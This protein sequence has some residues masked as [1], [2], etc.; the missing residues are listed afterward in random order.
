MRNY[1][2]IGLAAV[3]LFVGLR[4]SAAQDSIINEFYGYGVHAYFSGE[5][6]QAHDFLT[7]VVEQGSRDPRV[8]YFRGL[9]YS[10]L[11][12]P[13]QA[14]MDFEKGA[15]LETGGADRV[16]PIGRSLQRVQGKLRLSVEKHRR[17]ARLV[18][19]KR[20]M[21]MRAERYEN[22]RN[23]EGEVLR[24]PTR[25]APTKAE[26]LVGPA[27]A[28]DQSDPFG[29]GVAAAEPEVTTAPSATGGDAAEGSDT[30]G[31]DSEETIPAEPM[32]ASDTDPFG[33]GGGD[34]FG[35]APAVDDAENDPFA[36]DPPAM[37]D[38]DDTDPF[39]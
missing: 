21:K 16:Y 5:Y 8:Y 28:T 9:S 15:E 6:E 34:P 7:T 27:P 23:A 19:L 26:D 22:L 14:T 32:P 13:N 31:G 1:L 30:F 18:A 10:H 37:E 24:D 25:P 17:V 3:G 38:G 29:A 2:A 12:R 36:D 20:D 39:S 4:T 35:D 11:G 33:D